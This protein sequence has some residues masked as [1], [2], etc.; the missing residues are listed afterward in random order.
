[1]P[2]DFGDESGE[3]LFDWMLR[4]GQEAG[5]AAMSHGAARVSMAFRNS[6]GEI[7]REGAALANPQQPETAPEWAKLNLH[8]F[9]ELPEFETIKEV[10]DEKLDREALQHE[11]YDEG[12]KSFLIFRVDDAPEVARCFNELADETNRA[13]KRAEQQLARERGREDPDKAKSEIDDPDKEPLQDRVEAFKKSAELAERGAA[14]QS[15]KRGAVDALRKTY[16]GESRPSLSLRRPRR[17]RLRGEPSRPSGRLLG[18]LR[19]P[20][21]ATR[22][23]S[24]RRHRARKRARAACRHPRCLRDLG[25]LGPPGT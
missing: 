19:S 17:L 24:G 4:V 5:Q 14:R 22:L 20:R 12:D 9:K 21:A 13:C 25:N 6:V 1:M 16:R 10:I 2:S 8:E 23:D 15:S 11:F 3:K 7:S 18:S